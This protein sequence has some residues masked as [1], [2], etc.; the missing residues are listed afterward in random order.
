MYDPRLASNSWS[1]CFSL[2]GTKIIGLH[3]Q[4]QFKPSFPRSYLEFQDCFSK[5]PFRPKLV[6]CNTEAGI[7]TTVE[8]VEYTSVTLNPINANVQRNEA[9]LKQCGNVITRGPMGSVTVNPEGFFS[10]AAV[11]VVVAFLSILANSGLFRSLKLIADS[12][13]Q[14]ADLNLSETGSEAMQ[15]TTHKINQAG[16]F[17]GDKT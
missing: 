4:A 10:P 16:S 13:P 6:V 1:S 2:L 8:E 14:I 3:H 7:T 12:V 15:G 11:V 17:R 9:G 5:C